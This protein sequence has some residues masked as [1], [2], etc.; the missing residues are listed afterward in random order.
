MTK[1]KIKLNG[2]IV[3]T[4]SGQTILNVCRQNGIDIPAPCCD[5][6]LKPTGSCRI[7]A[8]EVSGKLVPSCSTYVKDGM[9]IQTN[10]S[11]VSSFR[12][13]Q[14]EK[15]L[16]E[17]YCDYIPPCSRACPANI[18]IRGFIKLINKGLYVE[19]AD[20]VKEKLPLPAIIGRICP[21]PCE[22]ACRRNL[23]DRPLAICSLKRFVG[24][25]AL[26]QKS[27][28]EIKPKSGFKIA[29][30]GSGPA[31]LSAAYYLAK[32]CHEVVIFEA[33]PGPG[34]MLRY[35]IPRYRLPEDI[36]DKEIS[37]ITDMGVSIKLNK[38][39]GRDFTIH[40]LFEDGFNAIF[41]ATGAHK[42]KRMNIEGEDLR[43]VISG[44]N[45]L[46]NVAEGKQENIKGSA[47]V[48][49]G[50]NTAVDAAC[51]AIRL[52]AEEVT[53]LYRRS[54]KEMPAN[55]REIEEAEA[56]GVKFQ[57]LACPLKITSN[58][59][60][61]VKIELGK[62]D[63]S[64][65]R[66]PAPVKGSEFVMQA[67][68]I[69]AAIGQIPDISFLPKDLKT[70][71]GMVT[72]DPNTFQTTMK[73]VF[74]GGDVVTRASTAV[75]AIASG[76]K[77]AVLIDKYVRGKDLTLTK[78]IFNAG[79]IDLNKLRPGEFIDVKR[80]PRQTMPTIE[81]NKR[82]KSFQEIEKG[83]TEKTAKKEALRCLECGCKADYYCE[84]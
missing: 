73:G 36:L 79:K 27:K 12:K 44:I 14:L 61:C 84:L 30:I 28:I 80:E 78:N 19:A 42:N 58:G 34:G 23:V 2:E 76:R 82:K 60:E 35:G 81:A 8:V 47:A 49:G 54:R 25:Y 48:V 38:R 52:G 83:F 24:D 4:E 59:I 66:I 20:L 51:T 29:V 31:G 7:C 11:S 6:Q 55:S 71:R 46:R 68:T 41:I 13:K 10:T 18:D 74:A 65:R 56:E 39:L 17:H 43:G 70:E 5:K 40:G 1:I 77:A 32:K 37:A 75:R 33:L 45:F 72:A 57:Y 21:H 64:G 9:I 22:K 62:P 53:V 50:G 67:D 15:I 3:Y 16:S 26:S 63:A 69:I